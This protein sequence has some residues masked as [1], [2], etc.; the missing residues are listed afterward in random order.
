MKIL[1]AIKRVIDPYVKVR[2]LKDLTGVETEQVKMAMNPFCEIAVEQAV[3]FKEQE[4]ANEVVVVTIG[5]TACQETLRRALAQGADRALWVATEQQFEPLNI[6]K[7][8]HA[9]VTQE[10]PDCV[11]LGKQSIDGDNNQTGQMLAALLD[12]PQGTFASSITV[13]EGSVLVTRE[14]D[15]GLEQL[16]LQLPAVLTTDLRLNEP[17]YLSLP[18]IMQAKKKP[19]SRFD[20]DDLVADL[21]PHHNVLKVESPPQRKAGVQ[22]N[23]VDELIDKLRHEAHVI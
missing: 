23:N 1:V 22:V 4:L 6:A 10:K 2:V 15:A 17:R 13:E 9:L 14:V 12:W 18:K 20:A 7:L 3:R 21:Q 19:L 8:L 5:P 16:R 11:I